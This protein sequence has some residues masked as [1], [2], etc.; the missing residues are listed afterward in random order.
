M[1]ETECLP[2]ASTRR[3]R[4]GSSYHAGMEASAGIVLAGGRSARMG[5]PKAALEWHGSTLLHRTVSI[6]A[7]ATGGPVVVVRAPGQDLPDLPRGTLVVEDP[8]EGKG[9]SR[10]SPPARRPGRPGRGRLHQLHRPAVPAS[11]VC[12]AGAARTWSS[13]FGRG[14]DPGRLPAGRARLPAAAGRRLPRR[15]GR[16][17][18]APG[19]GGTAAPGLLVRGVR[20]PQAGRRGAL[21]RPRARR[22]RSRTRLT[23]QRQRARRLHGGAGRPAPEVTVRLSGGL[24]R[25]SAGSGGLDWHGPRTSAPPPSPRP[26]TLSD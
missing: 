10:G 21:G 8:R 19:Q 7:R 11:G 15:A 13:A 12:P 18:R 26:R 1:D 9:P 6:V 25:D 3:G 17:R 5:T 23:R 14:C 22:A 20:G 4:A 16:Y 2:R 24:A